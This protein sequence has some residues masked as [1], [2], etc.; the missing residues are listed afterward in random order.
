MIFPM[1][2]GTSQSI[3]AIMIPNVHA[4][5]LSSSMNMS[6]NPPLSG[7]GVLWDK[8]VVYTAL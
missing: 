8:P 5:A 3:K 4:T 6:A 7:Y 2:A 1:G